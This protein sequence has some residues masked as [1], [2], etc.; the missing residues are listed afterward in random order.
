MLD[1]WAGELGHG[2]TCFGGMQCL[3][4][5]CVLWR[6]I[7]GDLQLNGVAMDGERKQTPETVAQT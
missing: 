6:G 2:A 4:M 3:P 7:C 1:R 5:L